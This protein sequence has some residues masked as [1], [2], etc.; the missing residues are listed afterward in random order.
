MQAAD[1][2][3]TTLTA[4]DQKGG[5]SRSKALVL[6]LL[7]LALP[8]AWRWTPLHDWINFQTIL[9]WQRSLRD[10]PAA[11]SLV[12]GV[13][14]LGSLFFF[15]V[16]ILNLATIF[17]FGPVWGNVYA[18]AGWFLS[19]S[20]GYFIG[21]LLGRDL[22]HKLAGN[23]LNRLI[24]RTERHGFLS[25]LTMR[26]IPVA[27]FTLVNLFIGAS[28][29]RFRDLFL[30]SLVGRVPGLVT[31]SLFGVQLENALRTPGLASLALLVFVLLVVPIV[32]SRW[33]QRFAA[34]RPLTWP[35]RDG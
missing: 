19:A 29:I 33:F 6:I 13:Y 28:G 10:D 3:G 8:L 18:L 4:R 2:S 16:T 34:R 20:A 27:P 23:R 5:L 30:A 1:R 25:V 22:L 15:P 24:S 21:R 31:L 7:V 14:L 12:I 26:V 9:E 32:I 17:A 35:S 11:P